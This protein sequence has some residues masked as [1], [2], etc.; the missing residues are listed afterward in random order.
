M[1]V[2]ESVRIRVRP[3][4][5]IPVLCIIVARC[6]CTLSLLT[7]IS[8]SQIT[9]SRST[10]PVVKIPEMDIE[11]VASPESSAPPVLIYVLLSTRHV[12]RWASEGQAVSTS[13]KS[14]CTRR[15]ERWLLVYL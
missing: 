9:Y 11:R 6:V 5:G 3:P 12:P 14:A 8:V 13:T 2:C 10:I 1:Y 15:V 4:P 7:E